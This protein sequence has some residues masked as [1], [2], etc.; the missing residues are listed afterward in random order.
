MRRRE[1]QSLEHILYHA[2]ATYRMELE[3]SVRAPA[4][5]LVE[6]LSESRPSPMQTD[7]HI[8]LLQVHAVRLFLGAHSLH[9]AQY[10]D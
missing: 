9:V 3:T 10:E 1:R 2:I 5:N 7:F 4:N 8:F 6:P